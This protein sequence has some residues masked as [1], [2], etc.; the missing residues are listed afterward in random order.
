[1]WCV[2]IVAGPC[3]I[4]IP[5][6]PLSLPAQISNRTPRE[7][8]HDIQADHYESVCTCTYISARVEWHRR[9]GLEVWLLCGTLNDISTAGLEGIV[10]LWQVDGWWVIFNCSTDIR[11]AG[12]RTQGISPYLAILFFL[13][14][15]FPILSV[16][17][18]IL[19]YRV[20][21]LPGHWDHVHWLQ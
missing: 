20:V 21:S 14:F 8:W 1:M 13:F 12:H 9:E 10:L 11:L 17:Y 4:M 16:F 6:A 7:K 19:H 15:F 3:M 5:T 2:L 18:C